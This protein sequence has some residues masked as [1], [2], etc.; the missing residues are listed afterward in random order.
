MAVRRALA[1]LL[2]IVASILAPFALG[3]VWAERTLLHT[4]Q[5]VETIAPL[6][7]SP[8]V[9][10]AVEVAVS[11]AIIERLDAQQR[12][13][14]LL[15]GGDQLAQAV[16]SG[17]NSAVQSGVERFVGGDR[18]QGAWVDITAR[19]HSGF[20]ALLEGEGPESLSL[21]DGQLVLDTNVVLQNV[22]AELV[23]RGVPFVGSLDLG[24][25]GR[26]IVVADTPNLQ[27]LVD[28]LAIFVPIA[29]WLWV[30]VAV[31]L[32]AGILLWPRRSRG[33]L[34]AGVGLALGGG[35]LWL[36]LELG[37]GALVDAAEQQGR[38]ALVG[39][40]SATLL[41]FLVNAALVMLM[42]GLAAVLA[43]WLGGAFP[44]GRR[45]RLAITDSAHRWGRPLAE[46]PVG[47]AAARAPLL[48][49]VLRGL[50]LVLAAWWLVAADRLTPSSIAWAGAATAA[51]LL[52]VEIIEGAGRVRDDLVSGAVVV[53]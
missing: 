3:A 15:P 36:G 33:L 37:Q 38:G 41:R 47:H 43:G 50:V 25:A 44:S 32:L 29:D 2:V 4:E 18:F 39:E 13:A 9:E 14:E 40:I 52:L 7:D 23:E 49:P 48:V 17:V 5:F 26:Q 8:E 20:V 30:V 10:R 19:L 51:G 1:A 46:G 31:M 16:A 12:V 22:Q 27:L 11:E 42:V 35:L 24:D 45:T 53:D 21:V 28:V 34:W 6:A